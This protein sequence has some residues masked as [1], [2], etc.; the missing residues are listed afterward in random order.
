MNSGIWRVVVEDS[1]NNFQR[2]FSESFLLIDST[3]KLSP[4]L[5]S[6]DARV[7]PAYSQIFYSL[8]EKY[9]CLTLI[10]FPSIPDETSGSGK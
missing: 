8:Y 7:I 10:A 3:D 5:V 4:F 2:K 1:R 9:F 6:S